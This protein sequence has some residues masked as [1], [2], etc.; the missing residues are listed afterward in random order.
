MRVAFFHPCLMSGGIQRVFLN[1]AR[2]VLEHGLAVDLVQATPENEMR[3]Q[4]PAGVRLVDLNAHR[5]LASLWPL[6]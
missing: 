2:G 4:V 5:A 1:L 6:V 3:D